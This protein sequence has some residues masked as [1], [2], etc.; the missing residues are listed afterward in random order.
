MGE[1]VAYNSRWRVGL[2]F[3]G[4][5][6]LVAGGMW[7]VGAF[8]EVPS[9]RRYSASYTVLIGWLSI[10][11]FGLC[12]VAIAKKFLDD[13]AQLK[14]GPSGIVWSPRSDLLIPWSEI[15]DVTTWRY[16]GQKFIILHLKDP[17]RFP[18]RGLTARLARANRKLTG[19]DISI[20]LTGTDRSYDDA[21]SAIA[22]FRE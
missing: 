11:F 14:I 12:A 4:A 7:M 18:A 17:G 5:L 8:G 13:R 1:F 15:A 22:R 6:G 3:L 21:M 19:G 10:V 9:S 20:S 16:K 2:I